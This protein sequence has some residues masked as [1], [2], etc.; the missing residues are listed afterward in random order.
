VLA[1]VDVV[2]APLHLLVF[3]RDARVDPVPQAGLRI[4]VGGFRAEP[5]EQ[6]GVE[7]PL[8]RLS[9]PSGVLPPPSASWGRKA[10]CR[11]PCSRSPTPIL[12]GSMLSSIIRFSTW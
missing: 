4:G 8:S 5:P 2:A 7:F 1:G 12:S 10:A 9:L 3:V 6:V 11:M